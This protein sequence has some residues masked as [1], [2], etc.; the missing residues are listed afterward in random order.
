M[1]EFFIFL[2]LGYQHITDINGYDHIL[3]VV[4]LCAI[5][6][7][8]D[9]KKVLVL[10]TAFTIGH[11]VTLALAALN[12][13]NYSTD[14]IEFLI[15]VTI[16]FTCLTNLFHKSSETVSGKENFSPVRYILALGFGLI[17]GM[18]FSNYLR[19]LL[20]K[21]QNIIPQLLA[22]N[23]GLEFGQLFII[24]IAMGLGFLVMNVFKVKKHTWN[25]ILS[26]FVAG[27]AFKL[28]TEKWFF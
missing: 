8:T 10:V 11:S 9:W 17:H 14:L 27:V 21:D 26:S 22:F 5:Y 28:M 20:G 6:R 3:F 15:P 25:L 12:V 24:A 16:I 18:G 13:I 1:T 19:S 4:A 7:I 23:I 2:K